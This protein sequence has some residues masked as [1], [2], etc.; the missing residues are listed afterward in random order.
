VVPSFL[1]LLTFPPFSGRAERALEGHKML[2]QSYTR[3]LIL[4]FHNFWPTNVL[5]VP[6]SVIIVSYWKIL[7]YVKQVSQM[8][9]ELPED[10]GRCALKYAATL[11]GLIW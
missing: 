2:E 8:S 7:S 6:I 4:F 1:P 10:R 3:H 5:L 9:F 11:Q